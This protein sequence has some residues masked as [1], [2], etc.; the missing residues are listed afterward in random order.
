MQSLISTAGETRDVSGVAAQE[1]IN[2]NDSTIRWEMVKGRI[3]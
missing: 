3:Q 1:E 2:L